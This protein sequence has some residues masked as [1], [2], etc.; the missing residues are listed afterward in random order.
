[1]GPRAEFPVAGL[2]ADRLAAKR[3][4]LLGE[5]AHI[6]PPIGAQGLNLGLRDAASLADCVAEALARGVTPAATRR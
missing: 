1:M 6:L 5:A 4:V 3:T 2:V